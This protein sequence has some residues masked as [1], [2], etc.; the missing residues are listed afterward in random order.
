MRILHLIASA[1]GGGATHVRDLVRG[2]SALGHQVGVGMPDDGGQVSLDSL[3]CR[4]VQLPLNR[5]PTLRL[6]RDISH[7]AQ[8]VDILHCHGARAALIGRLA[9]VLGPRHGR[10]IYTIH[11]FAAPHYRWWKRLPFLAI[12]R[13]LSCVTDSYIA[14]SGAE[15]SSLRAS[16]IVGKRPVAIVL[17]GIDPGPLLTIPPSQAG[18]PIRRIIMVCRLF[19]PRDFGTLLDAFAMALERI[20]ELHLDIVGDGPDRSSIE[21]GITA[22]G[23][24]D[25]VTIRGFVHPIG[26]ALA[27]ADLFVLSTKGWEGL[28]LSVLEAMAAARPVVASRVGGIPEAVTD[29]VTGILVSPGNPKELVDALTALGSDPSKAANMGIAGRVRVLQRFGVERMVRETI[30]VYTQAH[31]KTWSD[32]LI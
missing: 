1:R 15:A 28:P 32:P 5:M 26:S 6:L 23:L 7:L 12:E 2:M 19:R 31:K 30:E 21:T 24:G 18:R 20:P 3:P 16:G 22:R 4:V 14:V 11:G 10:L 29:G 27:E 8:S 13:L 9:W 25:V 17:N